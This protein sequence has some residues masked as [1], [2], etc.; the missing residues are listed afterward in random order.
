M[1]AT[2][3]RKSKIAVIFIVLLFTV[4]PASY[5]KA[6]SCQYMNF[7][8]NC[9][10]NIL[11]TL[12]YGAPARTEYIVLAMME[13]G[14]QYQCRN[15]PYSADKCELNKLMAGTIPMIITMYSGIWMNGD[16]P[17]ATKKSFSPTG[18]C[19]LI[20]SCT[21]DG[22]NGTETLILRYY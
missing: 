2:T 14:Y 6:L 15:T 1:T 18:G 16:F 7:Q 11:V 21:L 10:R 9:D 3:A 17:G 20:F 5:A 22:Y 19:N 12:M 8:S 13:R 4:F